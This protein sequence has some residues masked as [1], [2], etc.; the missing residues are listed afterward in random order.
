[1]GVLPAI[2]S[3]PNLYTVFAQPPESRAKTEDRER[4]QAT[5][6][7]NPL[8][9]A[10]QFVGPSQIANLN[11]GTVTGRVTSI[12]IDPA[13]ATGNTVYVGT[14]GGGVWKS[15][16]AAGAVTN[17]RFI[18]LTDTLPV[19]SVNAGT[20]AIPSLSIG[21]LS[22]SNTSGTDV[23][24]AG[25][26]DPNDAA[27]S[28]Y[29][30]GILRSVD[31]GNT[32]TLVQ[33]ASDGVAGNHTFAGL[34]VAGFAWSSTT[35]GLVV[36]ALSQS[37]EGV[38]V[39]AAD[40][41]YSV[42]GLYYSTNAGVSWQMGLV[43]DGSQVVQRPIPGGGPGN[44][45]TA[46]VWNP[47]RKMFYAALRFHGYYSSADGISWT[48]LTQQPG[49]RL[50]TT[51]CPTNPNGVGNTT[52]PIYRGALATQP[53]TGDTFAMTVDMNNLDQ[54]LYQDVCM[55]TGTS[56]STASIAFGKKLSSIQL[57]LGNGSTGIAQGDYNLSLAAVSSGIDTLLFAGTVDLYRCSVSAGCVLRNTTNAQNGCN[58]PAKV[59]PAQ[60]AIAVL[61]NAGTGGTQPLL[62]LG[63]DGGLWR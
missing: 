53:I 17:V 1:L 12:A 46:V 13:D 42:M 37:A 18:P 30:E 54:G 44:A 22:V 27:D 55:L 7:S 15:I 23:L 36:A 61:A 45:A 3:L 9:T 43:L 49:T 19:F 32:W 28:Y 48:R 40:S 20:A 56:C 24:L 47:V 14:T 31:G 38:L 39:N 25:T 57:E 29:G 50:T 5:A 16:N 8:N 6:H 11:Y 35:P 52:C 62:Y 41:N 58:A 59:S 60:H 4:A 26:G 51:A 34:S 63:N 2:E 33:Q 21:A 10:W